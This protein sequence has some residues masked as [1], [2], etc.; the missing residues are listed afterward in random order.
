MLG[1][2]W[3]SGRVIHKVHSQHVTLSRD[4]DEGREG[5]I[6]D[7]GGRVFQT[8]GFASARP[9]GEISLAYLRNN[10]KNDVV[11]EEMLREVGKEQIT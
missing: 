4:L 9:W 3:L 2:E 10:R 8:E 5:D 11:R 7:L 1:V 6:K